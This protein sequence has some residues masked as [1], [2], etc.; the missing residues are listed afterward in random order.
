MLTN[1]WKISKGIRKLGINTTSKLVLR[2]LGVYSV[3]SL[4]G[5]FQSNGHDNVAVLDGG[6]T[7]L[8]C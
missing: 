7:R 1:V 2:Y 6:I 5:C 4:G 8:D 3:Q